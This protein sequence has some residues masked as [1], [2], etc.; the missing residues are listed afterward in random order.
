M[1][2]PLDKVYCIDTREGLKALPDKSV[3]C[4]IT[5]PPYWGLRDYGTSGVV[6]DGD[7]E[8]A[9]EFGDEVVVVVRPQ[10]DHAPDGTFGE[11]R[12]TE[13]SRSGV[14]NRRSRGSFCSKCNAWRGSFGLEPT[15]ELYVQHLVAIFREVSRVLTD[16]GT[17]WLNLGDSYAANRAYQVP[18]TKGGPKCSPAQAV[19]GSAS[20]VPDGCK[21]KDLVGV[22]WMVAFAIRTDGWYLRQDII[23]SKPNPMPESVT[24]RC[25]RSHE[26]LF[27]LTKNSRYYFDTD[28]IKEPAI[29]ADRV[30]ADRF[31]GNKHGG[32]TTKHSDGSVF[33]NA[34]FRNKR[35]VWT[36][37]PKPFR[38]AHFAV[39]PEA[40][41]EP[42]VLSG[43]K[44]GDLVLD[45]F[46]GSGTVGVV[47]LRHSRHFVGFDLNLQY[48]ALAN[49]RIT[50][51]RI[52]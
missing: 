2:P 14:G 32:G 5:S 23:W 15:P 6:W 3:Q 37:T 7:P 26:Y 40:L 21:P 10:R 33:E 34:A 19:G 27:L 31:G 22:P 17:L 35:S 30:R 48:T 8:C 38:G 9:H 45:P 47:S 51:S 52:A 13:P 44:P 24:D 42:C 4:C 49:R 18:S 46:A 20:V 36:I 11:S 39:M 16:D 28:A 43:T 50:E 29:G 12:G 25:T 41:V 1:T